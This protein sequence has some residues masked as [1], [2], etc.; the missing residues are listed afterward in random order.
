MIEPVP[1]RGLVRKVSWPLERKEPHATP[2]LDC[3]CKQ[4]PSRTRQRQRTGASSLFSNLCR[5]IRCSRRA[6]EYAVGDDVLNR[7]NPRHW[8]EPN[9]DPNSRTQSRESR[10]AVRKWAAVAACT[11]NDTEGTRKMPAAPSSGV[12]GWAPPDMQKI[13]RKDHVK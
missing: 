5:R 11:G 8:T 2:S 7:N 1:I 12:G 6:K 9:I 10:P 3:I 13:E 4:M